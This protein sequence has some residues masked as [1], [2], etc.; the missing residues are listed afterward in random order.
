[1][2][3]TPRIS[4]EF[5]IF[6]FVCTHNGWCSAGVLS[7][8][9]LSTDRFDVGLSRSHTLSFDEKSKSFINAAHRQERGEISLFFFICLLDQLL[10]LRAS[11]CETRS[12]SS[13]TIYNE[14][15]WCHDRHKSSHHWH[16]E[17]KICRRRSCLNKCSD[18]IGCCLT[19]IK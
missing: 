6:G 2:W 5:S 13:P 10:L 3:R 16:K 7:P 8:G 17:T 11:Y 19:G 12:F 14:E 18:C 1:M 15:K 9:P 4:L